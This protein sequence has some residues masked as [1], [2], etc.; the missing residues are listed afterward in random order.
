MGQAGAERGRDL[1]D[2]IH[3]RRDVYRGRNPPDGVRFLSDDVV[4]ARE[5]A[6]EFAHTTRVPSM[7]L[8]SG[9]NG[10]QDI[11]VFNPECF[12]RPRHVLRSIQLQLWYP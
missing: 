2:R 11:Q 10:G 1:S 12:P 9:D 7:P 6:D 3:G 4:A 5:G 8:K